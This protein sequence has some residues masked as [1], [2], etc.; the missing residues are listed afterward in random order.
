M[1]RKKT[2]VA[3]LIACA[4]YACVCDLRVLCI[5]RALRVKR[6]CVRRA[7]VN[8]VDTIRSTSLDLS[9]CSYSTH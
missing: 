2:F 6:D 9:V 3:R 8:N 5:A 7:C 4:A 1:K